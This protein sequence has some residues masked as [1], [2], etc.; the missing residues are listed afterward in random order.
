MNSSPAAAAA[1][2]AVI[3]SLLLALVALSHSAVG[4]SDDRPNIVV[5]Y[6]DDHGHADLSCQGVVDDI[7]TPNVDALANNGVLARHGYSTAPQ[8]V[9]SR[10][11]LLIGKFQ[12]KFGVE[13]NGKSLDGFNREETIAERLQKAGYMTAQFGKWHLGPGPRITEHGFKHVF[14]QNSGAPF[15]ANIALDGRD[16]EMSTLRP[17]MYHVDG[18]SRAA[19]SLIE[20]YKDSPF[21]LYVAYRAPHVPLDAPQKYLDRF[22]GEMP[23]RRRQALAML[24]AVDDGV[25]LITETLAQNNLTEKT[26]IFY[27]GDNGAPLKIHKL[28]APGGG[29]GWDGSLNDP[30]NGEKGML[31]EGGMHVPFVISW[32]GTIPAGQVF[33]HPVSALDVAATA[34]ELAKIESKPGDFDGVN[35]IPYLTGEKK[36]APHEFLAWRWVAQSAIREGDWKLLRGGDREYLYHLKN[37]LQEQQNLAGEH[38]EIADRL[39]EKLTR[40]AS[41]LDPPG[42]AN[43]GMSQAATGYF[44]FYLDGKPAP[45]PRKSFAPKTDSADP[46][47]KANDSASPWIIRNGKMKV[48]RAGLQIESQ[49]L[50]E[51]KTPFITRNGLS[52]VGPVSVSMV[53]KTATS[54]AIGFAWRSSADK[55]FAAANRVNVAVEKSDQWQTIRTS[56]PSES[57]IIH[58]RVHVPAGITSI[59]SIELKPTSGKSVTLTQ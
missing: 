24:S 42:L 26:L 52:L 41:E 35:L 49:T 3:R 15:A 55:D 54:G 7:R 33:E 30:L 38:P 39:R 23:E 56:L 10:A 11:G 25:G 43:G 18:C 12:S 19:A 22:P 40:W 13:S 20:R 50:G 21:F 34:A 59:K 8:C 14:N 46:E 37:D 6:T 44:D 36:E 29:P 47:S 48:T 27:I 2:L 5:F 58:V 4:A 28:D 53:V 17:E 45:P 57:K 32:P 16:R 1:T 31:S 9:P 51:Q